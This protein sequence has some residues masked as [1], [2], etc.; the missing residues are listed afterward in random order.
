MQTNTD[1]FANSVDPDETS[2]STLFAI[3]FYILSVLLG[4]CA[5]ISWNTVVKRNTRYLLPGE[6]C[7]M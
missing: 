4:V 2:G 3:L 6:A 1:T 7:V 5:V